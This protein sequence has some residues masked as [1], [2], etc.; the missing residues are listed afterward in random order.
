MGIVGQLLETVLIAL[1]LGGFAEA[2]L[3]ERQDAITGAGQCLDSGFPG[4]C[5]EILAVQQH[6]RAAVRRVPGQCP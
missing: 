4:R 1:R 6:H 3:V 2:D 5:A